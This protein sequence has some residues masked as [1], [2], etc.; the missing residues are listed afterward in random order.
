[1]SHGLR[2]RGPPARADGNHE[3]GGRVTLVLVTGPPASGK[4][5][6]ARPLADHLGLPLLGKDTIKEALFD[7]LGTGDR[8]WSRRLGGASYAVLLALVRDIP[9][10]V[11]DANFYPAHGPALLAAC[12]RPIEVFCRCP[13]VE[14]ERRFDQRAF[15]RHPGHVDHTL[16]EDAKTRLFTGVAPL[17]LGGPILEVDTSRPVDVVAVATWIRQQPEWHAHIAGSP[18]S[19]TTP[20]RGSAG[21]HG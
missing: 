9:A 15:I 13:A 21:T 1:M 19:P 20:R 2:D 17:G 12:Q 14:V 4:T 5:T 11:V 8:A 6:L 10:A 3:R 16:D 7:T 18:E